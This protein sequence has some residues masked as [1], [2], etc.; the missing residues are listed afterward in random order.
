MYYYKIIMMTENCNTLLPK[1]EE[2]IRII[3]ERIKNNST[4]SAS[5]S[6]FYCVGIVDIVNSTISTANLSNSK[7]NTY[8]WTFLDAMSA[9]VERFG[10][11]VIKNLGDGIL[12]YFPRTDDDCTKDAFQ[13][14]LECSLSVID[15]YLVVN[16]FFEEMSLPRIDYRVSADYGAV[17]HC[18]TSR[19]DDIFGPTVNTCSKINGTVSPNK[20]VIGGDLYSIV[21]SFKEYD[22][23]LIGSYNVG[24]KFGYPVYTAYRRRPSFS[25]S[26]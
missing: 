14:V 24:Q 6:K 9:I 12:Y 13:N 3:A 19:G 5:S 11:K 16:K 25:T 21:R 22:F 17:A 2:L 4:M 10:A 7:I 15:S 26:I 8:Y 20:F 18:L 1:D 23:R